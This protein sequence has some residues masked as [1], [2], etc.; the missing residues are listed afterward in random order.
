[1]AEQLAV[2]GTQVKIRSPWGVFFLT[3]IT[4][5]IYYIVWYYKINRE[6]RD[7]A[8]IDV[9]RRDR[10][11]CDHVRRPDHHSAVR[12]LLQNVS[13]DPDGAGCRRRGRPGDAVA[14]VRACPDRVRLLAL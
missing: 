13:A 3:L 6:L 10:N 1:M 2:R 14:R 12:F 4:L 7:G 9:S 8:N 5:G 11:D